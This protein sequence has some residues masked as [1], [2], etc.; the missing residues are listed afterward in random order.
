[1]SIAE[2]YHRRFFTISFGKAASVTQ[3][4]NECVLALYKDPRPSS[5]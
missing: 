3:A 2:S 1:M 5:G 4:L